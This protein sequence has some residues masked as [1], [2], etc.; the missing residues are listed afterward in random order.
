MSIAR[1]VRPLFLCVLLMFGL[2]VRAQPLEVVVSI[3]PL[4]MI[5]E[6]IVGDDAKVH[7]I[8][9]A[10]V[11]PHEFALRVSDM[12]LINDADLAFWVGPELEGFLQKPFAALPAAKVLTA[13]NLGSIHWPTPS[14][15]QHDHDSEH[16]H[17]HSHAEGR[18]PHIW[19]NPDNAMVLARA[20]AVQLG[21]VR[22]GSADIYSERAEQFSRDIAALDERL[23]QQLAP[24]KDQGFA[25]YHDGYRHLVAHY[26]LNQVDYV[27]LTPE[28]RPGAR[29]LYELEEHLKHEAVCLF[30]E[31]YADTSAASTLASRVGLRTGVLDPLA[32]AT[33]LLSYQDLMAGLATALV[34]CLQG[35]SE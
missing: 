31:P 5:A 19:L 10:G 20:L 12:R 35:V 1:L 27:T 26:Q 21:Q 17:T 15:G 14:P 13:G 9:P 29:H 24:V 4:A 16:S 23:R 2:V 8:L 34:G 33:S 7:T 30:V 32:S 25:V 18:D 11:S 3:K 6:R 22:P 28:R